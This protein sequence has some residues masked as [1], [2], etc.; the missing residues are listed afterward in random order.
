MSLYR[1]GSLIKN[2]KFS[3]TYSY[4]K[5]KNEY[6]KL[7]DACMHHIRKGHKIYY[8]W[9]L[10]FCVADDRAIHNPRV[11]SVRF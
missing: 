5:A 4:S 9:F 1:F 11:R 3:K 2:R 6:V 10:D 7:I 8:I